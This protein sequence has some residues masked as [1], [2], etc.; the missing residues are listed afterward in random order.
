[1]DRW[2]RYRC[3]TCHQGASIICRICPVIGVAWVAT[4][5]VP[6]R[7]H[8]Y[9]AVLRQLYH[10]PKFKPHDL[11]QLPQ[12]LYSLQPVQQTTMPACT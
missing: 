8:V 6:T 10:D 12:T 11:Q 5:R 2:L 9:T 1:M 7:S 4:Y 3:C